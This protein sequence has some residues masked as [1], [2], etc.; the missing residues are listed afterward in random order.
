MLRS[1]Y[2]TPA[3]GKL[4]DILGGPVPFSS[5]FFWGRAPKKQGRGEASAPL[6]RCS[7]AAAAVVI[8][9][10][11]AVVIAA[12]IVAAPAAAAEQDNDEDDD[13]QAA[14]AAPTV[15]AAPHDEYLLIMKF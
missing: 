4:Q 15:I 14:V 1:I 7:A 13:P 6:A 10:A 11:A 3:L 8:V 2:D 9:V 5:K 12:A